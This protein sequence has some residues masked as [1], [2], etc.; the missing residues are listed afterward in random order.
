MQHAALNSHALPLGG[1]ELQ[2]KLHKRNIQAL[3]HLLKP[4]LSAL[5]GQIAICIHS[6]PYQM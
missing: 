6:L 5:P 4:Q 3:Q 2:R 1:L